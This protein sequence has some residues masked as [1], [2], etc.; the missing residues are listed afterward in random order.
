MALDAGPRQPTAFLVDLAEQRFGS[1]TDCFLSTGAIDKPS[2]Q[3]ESDRYSGTA[4]KDLQLR[5]EQCRSRARAEFGGERTE[6]PLGFGTIQLKVRV[7]SPLRLGE[8]LI[9]Q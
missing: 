2:H 1:K 4:R 6:G 7:L 5:L 3:V 8:E 9:E